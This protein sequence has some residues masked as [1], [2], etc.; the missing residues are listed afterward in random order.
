MK[1]STKGLLMVII[2]GIVFGTMPGAVTL[3]YGQGAVPELMV[4]FRY[5]MLTQSLIPF[6]I[7]E[8]GTWQI[9]K[10]HFFEFFLLSLVGVVTPLLLYTAYHHLATGLVTTIHFLYPAIVALLSVLFLKEKMSPIRIAALLLSVGGIIV[11]A[12]LSGQI[13][14]VGILITLAS[15]LTWALYIVLLHRVK[16]PGISSLQIL[17]FVSINSLVLMGIY[18]FANG[19]FLAAIPNVTPLGWLL[20]PLFSLIIAV[21]GSAFFAFGVRKTDAQ[22]S[23]IASTME[24]IVSILVG[25]IFLSEKFTVRTIIGCVMVLTAV[26]LLSLSDKNG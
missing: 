11:M 12:E 24:P 15:A 10:A 26:V 18:G 7:K 14:L 23:A 19:S 22:L 9:Y 20:M 5:A 13:S 4:F 6:I 8:K 2:S 1:N 17:F 16:I 3:C 25:I 21:L